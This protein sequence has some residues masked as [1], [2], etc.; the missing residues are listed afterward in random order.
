VRGDAGSDCGNFGNPAK[1]L[2]GLEKSAKNV[3][4]GETK[5]TGEEEERALG[6]RKGEF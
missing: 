5:G 2:A 1:S 3:R 4:V 6:E